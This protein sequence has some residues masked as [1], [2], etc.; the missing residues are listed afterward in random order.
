MDRA[1]CGRCGKQL[2]EDQIHD[3]RPSSDRLAIY[4]AGYQHGARHERAVLLR[5]IWDSPIDREEA[6]MLIDEIR[7]KKID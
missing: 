3:C 2:Y 7:K 1:T 4:E 5:M 6:S